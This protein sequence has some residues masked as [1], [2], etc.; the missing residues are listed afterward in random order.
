MACPKLENNNTSNRN[1]IQ[2]KWKWVES[3]FMTR[4]M[5]EPKVSTPETAGHEIM[6]EFKDTTVDVYRNGKV[7]ETY[8]YE[9]KKMSPDNQLF[10]DLKIQNPNSLPDFGFRLS[11]GPCDLKNGMLE[12]TGGY[13]DAGE[14]QKYK[15]M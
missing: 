5:K 15:R 14:N 6:L 8:Q 2:G 4:G 3:S 1:N 11:S 12:I 7:M 10:L 9:I 13:N